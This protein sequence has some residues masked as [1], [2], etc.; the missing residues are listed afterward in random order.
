MIVVPTVLVPT[1]VVRA[2]DA[3]RV[4]SHREKESPRPARADERAR[5]RSV[6][7]TRTKS[8]FSIAAKLLPGLS[9]R[10]PFMQKPVSQKK[11]AVL[12]A[13]RWK[14]RARLLLPA[15]Q[16]SAGPP[17]LRS[18]RTGAWGAIKLLPV[19]RVSCHVGKVRPR[20]LFHGAFFSQP[21]DLYLE[22][23][24]TRARAQNASH[25]ESISTPP[26]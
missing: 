16:R 17:M 11:G 25:A 9:G 5:S 2:S 4:R 7:L 20:H 18:P 10:T 22:D 14:H 8:C 13:T 26:S 3:R 19:M 1:Y 23:A 6:H 15:A 21:G 24:H 12:R